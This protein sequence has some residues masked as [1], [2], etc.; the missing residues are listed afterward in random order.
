VALEFFDSRTVDDLIA[1]RKYDK[2]VEMIAA[3]LQHGNDIRLRMQL[4]D[5]LILGGRGT[6]ALSWLSDLADDLASDGQPGKAIA[7]CKKIQKIDPA[8]PG[9]HDRIAALIKSKDAPAKRKAWNPSKNVGFMTSER[10]LDFGYEDGELKP[11][12]PVPALPA[13][14]PEHVVRR[15]PLPPPPSG[16][17][18]PPPPSWAEFGDAIAKPELPVPRRLPEPERE[19]ESEPPLWPAPWPGPLPKPPVQDVPLQLIRE[20][21]PMVDP[22]KVEEVGEAEEDLEVYEEPPAISPLFQGFSQ[23]ELVA[24]MGGL[25]LVT[26]EAGDII[27][28]EG[29][30]GDS[31]FV[32]T[33]GVAKAFAKAKDGTGQRFLR[34]MREG[35]FFGEASVLS[36]RPR[37]ATV[38]AAS[39]C[40]LL[41]LDRATFEGIA[42]IHPHVVAVL[43]DFYVKRAST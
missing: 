17:H 23:D 15:A 26:F 2:A 31:L 37:S 18:A 33:T 13:F 21:E 6:E 16:F 4:S 35:D 5:A 24:I 42:R 43:E 3:Q 1:R 34:E 11:P 22:P 38:T 8:Y 27:L 30:P 12:P 10:V 9:V 25:E 7:V 14:V 19:S 40:E 29:D 32:L 28:T 41:E 20:P 39:R 36:G